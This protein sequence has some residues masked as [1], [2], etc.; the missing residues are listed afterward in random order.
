M[1]RSATQ[2]RQQPPRGAR[3]GPLN[4][5]GHRGFPEHANLRL[6]YEVF[7][8]A[9]NAEATYLPTI[10]PQAALEGAPHRTTRR[11]DPLREQWDCNYFRLCPATLAV[12]ASVCLFLRCVIADRRIF[13]AFGRRMPH[14]A[15]K[16][17]KQCPSRMRRSYRM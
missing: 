15:V 16:C 3:D 12:C 5:D 10:R 14:R 4:D 9:D 7:L 13:Y 1:G 8:R 2:Q 6:V 11:R 17:I